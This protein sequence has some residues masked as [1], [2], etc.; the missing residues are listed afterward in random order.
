LLLLVLI[1]TYLFSAFSGAHL[2]TEIQIGLFAVVL[3]LAMRSSPL[4]G[5][6]PLILSAVT[7]IGSVGA[8]A[9]ARTGTPTG[10]GAAELWKALVLLMTAVVVV[11]GSWPS[12]R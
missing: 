4:P 6:W 7:V 1:G 8:F 2:T 10:E 3:L 11:G 5:R 9:V 12:P